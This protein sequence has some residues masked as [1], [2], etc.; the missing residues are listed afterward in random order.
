MIASTALSCEALY[1]RIETTS[2]PPNGPAVAFRMFVLYIAQL[3][4]I[5]ICL[6]VWPAS[7]SACSQLKE[8]PS[9]KPTML[10]VHTSLT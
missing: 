3:Q 1:G 10:E 4:P 8:Q 6:G 2:E 7:C 9:K 5:S